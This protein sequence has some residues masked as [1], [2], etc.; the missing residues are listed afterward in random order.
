MSDLYYLGS[1]YALIFI[2]GL[3]VG[4]IGAVALIWLHE[5]W[6]DKKHP[7]S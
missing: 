4:I 1:M 2:A 6:W 3:V 7:F 5:K